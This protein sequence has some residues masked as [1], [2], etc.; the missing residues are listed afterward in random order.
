MSTNL[1]GGTWAGSILRAVHASPG[2][3][4]A[5]LVRQLGMSSGLAADTVARLRDRRLIQETSAPRTGERG[6]PTRSLVAHPEGPV[7]AVVAISHEQWELCVIALGAE[8]LAAE[9]GRH[10]RRLGRLGRALRSRL[11]TLHRRLGS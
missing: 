5:Q 9:H 2:I 7:V 1:V 10:D 6:R 11:S 3:S 8:V 4:R